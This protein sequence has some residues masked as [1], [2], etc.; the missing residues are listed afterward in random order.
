[1]HGN[2]KG[3]GAW[4]G[5]HLLKLTW[6]IGHDVTMVDRRAV[7]LALAARSESWRRLRSLTGPAASVQPRPRTA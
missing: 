7:S 1:M 4:A 2:E 3:A 5:V 6:S